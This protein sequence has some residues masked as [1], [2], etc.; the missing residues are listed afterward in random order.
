MQAVIMA[1]GLGTRL[2]P[3]T[4]TT[5]KPMLSVAGRPI[6]EW[7]F[8]SLPPEVDEVVLVVNYLKDKIVGHFGDSWQGRKISY[9]EQTEL[10]GT[11]D[12]L[13][14]CRAILSGKFLVM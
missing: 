10:R 11:G 13:S 14:R 5:P 4:L 6:L 3:H 9:V 1:A 2:R 12:A 8:A 7:T